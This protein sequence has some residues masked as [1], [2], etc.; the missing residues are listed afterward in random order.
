MLM[1]K[2]EWNT[3]SPRNRDKLWRHHAKGKKPDTKG[4]I[5]YAYI[6]VSAQQQIHQD[7]YQSS[8]PWP[9][10]GKTLAVDTL[11]C[12]FKSAEVF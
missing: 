7:R 10:V 12:V 9:T 3:D 11:G 6:Y 5:L 1:I 8:Q 4:H 2:K